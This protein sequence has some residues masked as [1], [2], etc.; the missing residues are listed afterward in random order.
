MR[1]NEVAAAIHRD[2]CEDDRNGYSW[3][4]RHGGDHPDGVKT[5]TIDGRNYSYPLGSFDCSSSTIKAWELA[6]GFGL[7]CQ[8]THNMKEAFLATGLFEWHG[9]D[10]IADTGDL[11]LNEQ[12]HVAMCQTQV[13][14]MLSEFS[15]SENGDV[16][17]N[18]VGD[19]TGWEASVH[20]Y[21]DYPWD[22]ILHY[23]GGEAGGG[24]EP[25]PAPEPKPARTEAV[26]FRV[27][28][29]GKW[30]DEGE[31]GIRTQPITGI[32]ISMPGW[33]QVCT[34]DHGWLEEVFGFDY[35]IEDDEHGYAGWQ[36]SPI[37]A[38]RCYYATGNP[39]KNGYGE[40]YYRVSDF[41]HPDWWPYQIDYDV[42]LAEDMD[43]YAGN[44]QP[45]DRFEIEIRF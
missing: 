45:I 30:L 14:D 6:L 19:Q 12:N 40:A 27:R 1:A 5:L 13:P 2:M 9:M 33:Y 20:G 3:S 22:G 43:G 7:A 34:V 35:N 39:D 25:A 17:N 31:V 21:Y 15:I 10:F 4:P 26:K 18:Q 36:D 28:T 24:S 29:G 42:N 41:G 38:V 11:Y 44:M 37:I 23:I 16:Y 32:A 8:T